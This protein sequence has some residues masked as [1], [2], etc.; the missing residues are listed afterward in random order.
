M[1]VICITNISS[2]AIS[3]VF[4]AAWFLTSLE[5]AFSHAKVIQLFI[6]CLISLF[7]YFLSLLE[8]FLASF[9]I[10]FSMWTSN[11][12]CHM[13]DSSAGKLIRAL[14]IIISN[15]DADLRMF[16]ILWYCI[17]KIFLT[18]L[19]HLFLT[20]NKILKLSSRRYYDFLL[21]FFL[22]LYFLFYYF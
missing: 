17:I 1:S 3:V 10:Y 21:K 12:F 5:K 16:E 2:Q 18:I 20:F 6:E 4:R 9:N 11:S 7:L 15:L 19:S 22:E 8:Y 13:P 14:I